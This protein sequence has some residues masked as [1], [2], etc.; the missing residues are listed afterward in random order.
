MLKKCRVAAQRCKRH[1][2]DGCIVA[3]EDEEAV[4]RCPQFLIFP[5]MCL[6][7]KITNHLELIKG[8]A[9]PPA[10][11]PQLIALHCF[12]P[13]NASPPAQLAIVT[14]IVIILAL[15]RKLSDDRGV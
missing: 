5:I 12:A 2:P 13:I 9:Y 11:C 7:H 6:L 14:H 10:F 1:K 8:A 3:D 4:L 15:A